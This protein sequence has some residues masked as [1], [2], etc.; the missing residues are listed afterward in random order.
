MVQLA[1]G[2][3]RVFR[4]GALPATSAVNG[5]GSIADPEAA[6]NGPM[7]VGAE[8][9]PTT[10]RTLLTVPEG[11]DRTLRVRGIG[12]EHVHMWCLLEASRGRAK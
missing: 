12:W 1:F 7:R 8:A 11:R 5:P 4:E 9:G 2:G 6:R 10:L 3:P